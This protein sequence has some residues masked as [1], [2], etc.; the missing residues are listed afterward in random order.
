MIGLDPWKRWPKEITLLSRKPSV[1]ATH[2]GKAKL[3]S[4][5]SQRYT[6]AFLSPPVSNVHG[7]NPNSR[8]PPPSSTSSQASPAWLHPC[9]GAWYPGCCPGRCFASSQQPFRRK[10]GL[11]V[12]CQMLEHPSL[13]ASLVGLP[14]RVDPLRQVMGSSS[15]AVPCLPPLPH[16]GRLRSGW[17][18][19]WLGDVTT[20][21]LGSRLSP[22]LCCSSIRLLS[23]PQPPG[24]KGPGWL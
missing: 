9:P 19:G 3:H 24:L 18:G 2:A 17:G 21:H 4:L 10:R 8:S 7:L 20:R 11:P 23:P 12:L 5:G 16:T 15:S 14:G 6:H 13:F 1:M 22:Q